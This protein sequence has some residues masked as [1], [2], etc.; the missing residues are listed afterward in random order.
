RNGYAYFLS[1]ISQFYTLFAAADERN[2][3]RR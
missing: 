3:A 1:R 2:N